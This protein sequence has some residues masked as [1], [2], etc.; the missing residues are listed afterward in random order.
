MSSPPEE[1][2]P[3]AAA[4]AAA[5]DD[6]SALT[7][8]VVGTQEE[9]ST[10]A[11]AASALLKNKEEWERANIQ[12]AQLFNLVKRQGSLITSNIWKYFHF[13]KG[14]KD[15]V[16]P[17]S[18]P[19]NWNS[20]FLLACCNSCGDLIK[21]G[22]IDSKGKEV[23]KRN[24][25]LDQHLNSNKHSTTLSILEKLTSEG[26][27]RKQPSIASFLPPPSIHQVPTKLKKAHQEVMT[28]RFIAENA[29]GLKIVE[30][31]SFRDMI[32]SFNSYAKPMSNKRMKDIIIRLEDAMRDAAIETMRGQSVCITMDHW[33]SKANQ[34]YTGMTA[35]FIDDDFVLHD[36]T[37]GMFLHQGGTT[38][39]NLDAAYEDLKEV[40]LK[41]N[42]VADIFAATTDTTANM[43]KF[44]IAL[45]ERG[46]HHVYCTDHVLQLTCKLCYE[47]APAAGSFGEEFF[48]SVQKARAI[49]SFINSSSQALEKLKS[50]QK[51]LD[52]FAGQKVVGVVTDVVTRWWSTHDMIERILRLRHAIWAMGANDELGS[53]QELIPRDWDNLSSIMVVL[54]PFKEAQKLLEGDKYVTASW[55]AF[56]LDQI[57]KKLAALSGVAQPD[58]ASKKLAGNMLRDFE[59]RWREED[60]A[61]FQPEVERAAGNRQIGI[62]PALL[63][64]TFLDPRFKTLFTVPDEGS[65]VAIKNHVLELMKKSEE[66]QQATSV[67]AAPVGGGGGGDEDDPMDDDD[68]EDDLLAALEKGVAAAESG[69]AGGIVEASSIEDI[70][71]DELKRYV[72]TQ[73][74]MARKTIV[75]ASGERKK[76]FNDPLEW[77][78]QNKHRFPI[79]ARLAKKFLAI[80]A[81]SA[82]AERV[83][84]I[85]SKILS[86][87]RVGMLGPEMAGKTLY[88]SENWNNWKSHLN[89]DELA[90]A[91]NH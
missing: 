55:V 81:T 33:T 41:L 71:A 7:L 65:K 78:K 37:L 58:T 17:S 28:A 88:V 66:E 90:E 87:T 36:H 79:L 48:A 11:A 84:S 9:S 53:C 45:E 19:G 89:Y 2:N 5:P 52:S 61:T 40:R 18:L 68:D 46:V 64:A 43:N 31:E 12:A 4:A 67:A 6:A 83:F 47:K 62:H 85:A 72:D 15:G 51:T 16:D 8:T 91:M 74:L 56:V 24:S 26:K 29:L 38:S 20:N 57:R 75:L 10:T 1:I 49:V 35:H 25:G 69:S 82:P 23:K 54:K 86:N 42:G 73:S 77:W 30:T 39:A 14:V 21:F 44:G 80:T 13:V 3:D 60:D 32:A 34:N 27:K 70:C 63:V 50:Y 59:T 76:V 22:E